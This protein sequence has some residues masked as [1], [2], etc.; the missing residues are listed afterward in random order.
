ML[1]GVRID[2]A[3]LSPELLQQLVSCEVISTLPPKWS[4]HA[5]VLL[6]LADI[7]AL[8]KH[9]PCALSSRRIKRFQQPKTSV[10]SLFAKKRA[11]QTAATAS[12]VSAPG[13]AD[14][15]D[16]KKRKTGECAP[17]SQAFADGA[18]AAAAA[19]SSSAA[20]ETAMKEALKEVDRGPQAMEGA[21]D[22]AKSCD[23]VVLSK[24]HAERTGLEG[25]SAAGTSEVIELVDEGDEPVDRKECSNKPKAAAGIVPA[26]ENQSSRLRAVKSRRPASVNRKGSQKSI[27]AF[28]EKQPE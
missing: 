12:G 16:A 21:E 9:P 5:A 4:D 19:K 13:V 8:P 17:G 27:R 26:E 23:G 11:A 10:A 25:A 1:Q 3:L 24:E 7:P 6:E 14:S 18:S 2:Y 20:A 28:F 22:G 15:T